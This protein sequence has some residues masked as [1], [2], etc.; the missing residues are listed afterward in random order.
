MYTS[1]TD[2]DKDAKPFYSRCMV[3]DKTIFKVPLL[4]LFLFVSGFFL[5]PKISPN[6]FSAQ[7][8][9]H[10]Y[11]ITYSTFQT[12]NN[13][14][15]MLTCDGSTTTTYAGYTY[16][17][18]GT[19]IPDVDRGSVLAYSICG[20]GVGNIR[21]G[22]NNEHFTNFSAIADTEYCYQVESEYLQAELDN[23]YNIYN[24]YMYSGLYGALDT[25]ASLDCAYVKLTTT[26]PLPPPTPAP[27][28][29]TVPF[30]SSTFQANNNH[31]GMQTCDGL[32][33]TTYIGYTIDYYAAAVPTIDRNLVTGYDLCAKGVGNIRTGINT[34]N[35][36][37][38]NATPGNEYCFHVLNPNVLQAEL[39]NL[40]SQNGYSGFYGTLDSNASLDCAY[41]KLTTAS[42]SRQLTTL[43]PAK[44]WIGLKNSDDVGVKFD[45]KAEVYANDVLVS[46]GETDSVVAGSSGFNNAKLDTISFDSFTPV[47]FPSG[48]SLSMKLYVRNACSGSGHNSGTS[49]LWYNDSVANSQFGATINAVANNYYLVNNSLL[50]LSVGS[51]PRKTIDV[52]SGAKCSAFKP[53]GTWTITP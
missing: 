15:D 29:V 32:N 22:I 42:P 40:Y 51:G 53:F 20:K 24:T 19:L 31:E 47:D 10:I 7:A 16:D 46:S 48:T 52:Q 9:D 35:F 14:A 36:T 28:T 2:I 6:N 1:C 44:I 5:L 13:F 43:N 39:D 23:M 41:I 25:S 34:E 3:I 18:F 21:F 49:R 8:S 33:N 37:I 17:Y 30:V 4:F 11:P 38:F 50:N 27:P 45:L 26:D 12:H